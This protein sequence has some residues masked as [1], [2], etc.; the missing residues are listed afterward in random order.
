ME[1][2]PF[3]IIDSVVR[4]VCGHAAKQLHH[5]T[6]GGMNETYRVDVAN[7]DSVIVRIARQPTP[8]FIDEAHLIAQA[9]AVGV[10]A[11]DVLGVEQVEHGDELLSFSVLQLVPGRAL[12]ELV[13]TLS[14]EE[15]KRIIVESG[16]LLARLHSVQ[17]ERGLRHDLKPLDDNLVSRVV[18]VADR[19]VGSHAANVVTRGVE[20]LSNEIANRAP[21]RM[22]LVHGD[23]LPKHFLLDDEGRIANVLDW[24]FAGSASP[25]YDI[26]HWEVAASGGLHDFTEL[27][28]Q[29]Y[30]QV[31]D[32]NA[33]D[34]AW[35]PAYTIDFALEILGWE[36][37]ARFERLQRC[38]DVIA[39]HVGS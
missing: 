11:P 1:K 12:D 13:G 26:A 23:W 30:S 21:P 5:L 24:E 35:V 39:R 36:N 28:C 17:T 3:P 18:E 19:E 27:L 25:A 34:A 15:I 9:R 4:A 31:A 37:P 29:G 32:V 10:P 16:E 22:S 20:L 38:V 8:W 6:S 2:T 33:A 14:P 7:S